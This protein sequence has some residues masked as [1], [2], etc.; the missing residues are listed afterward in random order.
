MVVTFLPAAAL[1]GVTQLRMAS[2]FRC[3]VQAPQSPMPQPNLVPVSSSSSRRYQR[4]GKSPSPSN[5]RPLP[6]T[7]S[8]I[9][10]VSVG[11]RDFHFRPFAPRQ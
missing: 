7:E 5:F 4:S 6:F 2:P 8:S 10:S 3:T 11:I 1:S 9:I